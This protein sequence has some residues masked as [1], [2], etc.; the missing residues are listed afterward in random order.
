MNKKILLLSSFFA[1][2]SVYAK[3]EK[4]PEVRFPWS[5]FIQPVVG[6]SIPISSAKDLQKAYEESAQNVKIKKQSVIPFGGALGGIMWDNIP[7]LGKENGLIRLSIGVLYDK[8]KDH[9]D[10]TFDYKP[11][12]AANAIPLAIKIST[13]SIQVP[14]EVIYNFFR[15]NRFMIFT[16][17]GLDFHVR[18]DDEMRLYD[19]QNRFM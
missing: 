14:V 10:A 11:T 3:K 15:K 5:G 4:E 17:A 13:E 1:L 7:G 18:K 6:G 12:G 2:T 16:G 8:K 19:S 9:L